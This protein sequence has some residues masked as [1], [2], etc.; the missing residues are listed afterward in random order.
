MN[1]INADLIRR[2]MSPFKRESLAELETFREIGSTNSYL[3]EAGKPMPG[4]M[5]VAIA[6][7]Q[8]AGRGRRDKA[9]YSPPGAGLWMSVAYSF[10]VRPAH[11]SALTL[12][13][14]TAVASEL[15]DLGVGD[16]LLKWP[17]DL[18]VDERKLGGILLESRANG[19]TAVVGIGINMALPK[20][21]EGHIKATRKPIDLSVLLAAVPSIDALAAQL[22]ERLVPTLQEFNRSGF[23]S[24]ATQWSKLDVLAGREIVVDRG[25]IKQTGIARGIATDGALLLHNEEGLQRIISGSVSTIDCEEAVA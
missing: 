6:E 13:V 14:G 16:I 22:I 9:W 20:N 8:T 24:F 25:G 10:T 1:T 5:R 7:Q 2:A 11:M 21:A 15:A 12:A 23:E 3:L 19:M 17:N 4:H 18:L